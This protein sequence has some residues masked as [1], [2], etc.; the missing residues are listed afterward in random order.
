MFRTRRRRVLLG[1]VLVLL[2]VYTAGEL[3]NDTG[4]VRPPA[5]RTQMQE[6]RTHE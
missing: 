2:L 6:V 1:V 3:L 4:R 5:A